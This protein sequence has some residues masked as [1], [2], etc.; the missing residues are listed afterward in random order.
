MWKNIIKNYYE[1]LL[2]PRNK[3]I[4]CTILKFTSNLSLNREIYNISLSDPVLSKDE[5]SLISFILSSRV[6]QTVSASPHK[7]PRAVKTDARKLLISIL[8]LQS[9]E[10]TWMPECW[11]FIRYTS[12]NL[13][14][15]LLI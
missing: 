6:T 1:E 11:L 2:K 9:L 8:Y 5:G 7:T 4:F 10:L 3:T 14:M 13:T 15:N 12:K